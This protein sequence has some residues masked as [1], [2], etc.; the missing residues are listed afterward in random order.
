MHDVAEYTIRFIPTGDTVAFRYIFA[1]EEY[2]QYVCTDFNDVFAFFLEGPVPGGGIETQ[3]LA[4]IPGTDLPVSINSVNNG[5]QGSFPTSD[6]IYCDESANG[7]L[8]YAQFFNFNP[9]LNF[10]VHNGF[11]DV[12]MAKSAVIPCQEYTMRLVIA[13]FG[14]ALWDSAIFFEA[15]SFCSFGDDHESETLPVI[16]E[17]CAPP[18]I[19]LNLASFPPSEYPLTFTV[20]GTAEPNA[21]YFVLPPQGEITTP[22]DTWSLIIPVLDDGIVEGTETIIIDIT[23]VNCSN[24]TFTLE[25]IDRFTIEGPSNVI[26]SPEPTTLSLAGDP[27]LLADFD[28]LWSTGDT[29]TSIDIVPINNTFYTVLYSNGL[30]TC[31]GFF[32]VSIESPEENLNLILCNNEEGIIV[33]G[34]LYDFY[35]QSGVEILE[36]GKRCRL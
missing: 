20:S 32:P 28:I 11:T 18:S 27:D 33:N 24:K 16:V 31:D 29:T 7:S 14:D 6:L 15:E 19:D 8:D 3:N 4:V 9:P 12:F 26:C 1:S 36:G 5:E 10:P 2:P 22:T 25:I 23:G 21:D 17:A 35:N 13:D 34:T 30:S